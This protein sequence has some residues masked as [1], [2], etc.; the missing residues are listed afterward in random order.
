MML[1]VSR[2]NL[3]LIFPSKIEIP[4][5]VVLIVETARRPDIH[6]SMEISKTSET[7][8][9]ILIMINGICVKNVISSQAIQKSK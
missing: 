7:Y 2:W 8:L 6:E 3:V 9:N 4:R 1:Q 5:G